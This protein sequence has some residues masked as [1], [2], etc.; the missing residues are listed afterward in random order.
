MKVQIMICPWY[1]TMTLDLPILPEVG[2]HI[3]LSDNDINC[4]IAKVKAGDYPEEYGVA[5]APDSIERDEEGYWQ[6]LYIDTEI[7]EVNIA[8]DDEAN[9]Y[10]PQ[11]VIDVVDE[12]FDDD[13]DD[14]CEYYDEDFDE[15][16]D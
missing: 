7:V 13:D 2:M 12:D 4:Y 9:A 16:R 10:L 14:D 3:D 8:W 11:A 15:D 1:Q 5:Q 6:D